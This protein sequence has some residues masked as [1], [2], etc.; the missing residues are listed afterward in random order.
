[1]LGVS[2][3]AIAAGIQSFRGVARRFDVRYRSAQAVYI[4]DYAHTH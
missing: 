4:D 1:L 2:A 3:E